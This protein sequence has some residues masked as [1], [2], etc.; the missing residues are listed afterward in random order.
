MPKGRKEGRV[1][2][3]V[4]SHLLYSEPEILHTTITREANKGLCSLRKDPLWEATTIGMT[5]VII[6]L[7]G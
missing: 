7:L 2:A 4:R 5:V 1:V 6:S 3:R